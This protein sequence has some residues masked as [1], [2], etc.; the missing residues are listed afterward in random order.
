MTFCDGPDAVPGWRVHF[1]VTNVDEAAAQV[2]RLGG[3]VLSEA[4]DTPWGRMAEAVDPHGARFV[5][6]QV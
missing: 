1:G 6:F 5:L 4:V 3:E 2:I